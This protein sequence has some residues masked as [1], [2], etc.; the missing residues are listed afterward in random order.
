MPLVQ[1]G[2]RRCTVGLLAGAGCV[3]EAGKGAGGRGVGAAV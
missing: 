3:C 2:C 1:W